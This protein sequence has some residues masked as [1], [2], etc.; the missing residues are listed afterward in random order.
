MLTAGSVASVA[1]GAALFVAK[2]G[3]M[4]AT[5]TDGTATGVEVYVGQVEA[6]L[7]AV[8]L[9]AGIVGLALALTLAAARSLV[10]AAAVPAPPVVDEVGS[11]VPPMAEEAEEAEEAASPARA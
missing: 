11:V 4:T 1:A 5:L 3:V 8:L 10:P 6:V 9:G 2:A 7:G